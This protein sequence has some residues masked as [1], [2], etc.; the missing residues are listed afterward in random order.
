MSISTAEVREILSGN[1]DCHE[2]TNLNFLLASAM[3]DLSVVA[4]KASRRPTESNIAAC[5][6]AKKRRDLDRATSLSHIESA[7]T[8]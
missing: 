4:R 7:H 2:C 6:A 8:P 1:P 3:G 5:L